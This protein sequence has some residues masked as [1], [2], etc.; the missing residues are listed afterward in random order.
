MLFSKKNIELYGIVK[1]VCDQHLARHSGCFVEAKYVNRNGKQRKEKSK[2]K[3]GTTKL[4]TYDPHTQANLAI[5]F[6]MKLGG[7][8]FQ[9][10][11]KTE[12]GSNILIF[13]E[14]EDNAIVFGA[15]VAHPAG[16]MAYTPS[17]ASVVAS[18]DQYFAKFSLSMRL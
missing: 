12:D 16:G 1:R 2:N 18:S 6:N 7:Q 9:I 10:C 3:D 17:V 15:D 8:N 13:R 14:F 4:I 5:K 11:E